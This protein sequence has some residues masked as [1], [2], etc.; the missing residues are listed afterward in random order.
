M[1]LTEVHSCAEIFKDDDETESEDAAVT[2]P[3]LPNLDAQ[4]L[5]K[6]AGVITTLEKQINDE[7][8]YCTCEH[9]HQRSSVTSLK[10][11]DKKFNSDMWQRV[12]EY[13]AKHDPT[14][15][16]DTLWM[17]QLAVSN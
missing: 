6:H 9:L 8:A 11:S 5:V 13:V 15:C 12:K 17:C 10:H 1:E 7:F 4:L 16:F 2:T 3:G 14:G